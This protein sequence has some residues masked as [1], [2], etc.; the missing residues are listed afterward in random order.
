[1]KIFCWVTVRFTLR[2]GRNCN[3]HYY[4]YD[5]LMLQIDDEMFLGYLHNSL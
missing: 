4:Y 2:L 5:S 3:N 1:M